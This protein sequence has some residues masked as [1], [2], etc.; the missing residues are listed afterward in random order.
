M[1]KCKFCGASYKTFTTYAASVFSCGTVVM[2]EDA[3]QTELCLRLQQSEARAR[4][5]WEA[6][7]TIALIAHAG[8]LDGMTESDALIKIRRISQP[9]LDKSKINRRQKEAT[10]NA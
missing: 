6:L 7:D 4:Q 8:G 9:W 10:K 3:V 2:G 5:L 1:D